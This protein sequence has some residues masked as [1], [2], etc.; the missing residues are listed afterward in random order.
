MT[1]KLAV[2]CDKCFKN[3]QIQN[4]VES[5]HL[6]CR[7]VTFWFFLL[8]LFYFILNIIH[9]VE[10]YNDRSPVTRYKS[11]HRVISY[12]E[13]CSENICIYDVYIPTRFGLYGSENNN[14]MRRLFCLYTCLYILP[15]SRVKLVWSGLKK[16]YY[17]DSTRPHQLLILYG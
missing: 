16:S 11:C 12:S 2:W 3:I 6:C 15:P 9:P 7:N 4:N 8:L 17:K 1:K 14:I 10:H 5:K 13:Y